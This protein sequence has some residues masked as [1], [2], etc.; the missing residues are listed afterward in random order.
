LETAVKRLYEGMF[1]VDSAQASD[2]D[3]VVKTIKKLLKRSDAE[4]I[5]IRNWAERRLAYEIDHKSRGTY[6]LCFFKADGDKIRNI[7][8]DV[9]LS[10]QVMRV[11]ILGTEGR[12]KQ[13]IERDMHGLPE[14][15]EEPKADKQVEDKTS[16]EQ[17]DEPEQSDKPAAADEIEPEQSDKPAVADETEPEQSDEPAVADA[18]EPVQSDEPAAPDETEP[19]Q[20]DEPTAADASEPEESA[21]LVSEDMSEPEKPATTEASDTTEPQQPEKEQE[22]KKP[23]KKRFFN[24]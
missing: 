13:D 4:I 17:A 10:E 22:P 9:Q 16:P 18:I 19:E 3:A 2:W 8:K 1:L 24:W 23:D 7:E 5:T 21:E 20:S 14:E 6:V 12:E 15:K 11:L